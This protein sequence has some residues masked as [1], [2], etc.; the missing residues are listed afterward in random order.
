MGRKLQVT[1]LSIHWHEAIVS[2]MNP[3]QDEH[4]FHMNVHV[5]IFTCEQ[6]I[7]YDLNHYI[8]KKTLLFK[9]ACFKPRV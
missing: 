2:L 8:D 5:I 7:K 6:F 3:L 4:S 9:S 1:L